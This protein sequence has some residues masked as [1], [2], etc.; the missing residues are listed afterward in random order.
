[1]SANTR[2][3][4]V[5]LSPKHFSHLKQAISTILTTG[6]ASETFA[7]I[8][9]GLP[10]RAVYKEYYGSYRIDYERNLAPS[11]EAIDIVTA[12]REI[13]DLGAIHVDGK[14]VHHLSF[15]RS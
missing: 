13:F 15:P 14:V 11:K 9:D 4:L 8:V 12:H 1:M 6:L 2:V 3:A 5:D 10:T 7:Q